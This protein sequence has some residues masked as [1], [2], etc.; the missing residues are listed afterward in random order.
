[1][2]EDWTHEPAQILT[3][4][5]FA[6]LHADTPEAR[7][8]LSSCGGVLPSYEMGQL[9]SAILSIFVDCSWLLHGGASENMAVE[10]EETAESAPAPM[11][12]HMPLIQISR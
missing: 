6:Y 3:G 11:G 7:V 1:M 8:L 5:M 2:L 12:V 9:S 10:Q 4:S